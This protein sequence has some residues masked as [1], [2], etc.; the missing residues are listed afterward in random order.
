MRVSSDQIKKALDFATEAHQNQTRKGRDVLFVT[1]PIRVYELISEYTEDENVLCAALLHDVVE[2]TEKTME[3]IEENFNPMILGYI[4]ELSE[5]K[6]GNKEATWYQRKKLQIKKIPTLSENALLIKLADKISN[7]EDLEKLFLEKGKLNFNDFNQKDPKLQQWYYF[8][9]YEAFEKYCPTS[10]RPLLKQYEKALEKA[11]EKSYSEYLISE[12]FFDG[13]EGY[14]HFLESIDKKAKEIKEKLDTKRRTGPLMIEMIGSPST[15]K[16]AL[17]SNI[18][19]LLENHDIKVKL[20]REKDLVFTLEEME[21]YSNY[22]TSL[23][24]SPFDVVLLDGAITHKR[25]ALMQAYEQKQFS[26]YDT[27]EYL[28]YFENLEKQLDGEV[29][30]YDDSMEILKRKYRFGLSIS[31][32]DLEEKEAIDNYNEL[33]KATVFTFEHPVL[34]INYGDGNQYWRNIMATNFILD[35]VSDAIE[36]DFVKPIE[37]DTKIYYKKYNPKDNQ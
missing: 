33:L 28:N 26:V 7:A 25:I 10:F 2:D 16:S 19:H 35:T 15:G 24:N 21:N 1:H 37:Q 30:I 18:A 36:K 5:I 4:K 32:K 29:A 17:L 14:Y 6:A 20:V 8:D 23:Q 9:C 31:T 3:D 22:M 27:V 13:R 34:E 11:F 12:K